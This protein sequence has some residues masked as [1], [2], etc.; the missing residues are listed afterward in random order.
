MAANALLHVKL[1]AKLVVVYRLPGRITGNTMR[2]TDNSVIVCRH[3]E[4]NYRQH[5]NYY[6][7]PEERNRRYGLRYRNQQNKNRLYITDN[8]VLIN[9][10]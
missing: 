1:V 8:E 7:K 3:G 9:H 10:C 5:D 2:L 4:H 6:R